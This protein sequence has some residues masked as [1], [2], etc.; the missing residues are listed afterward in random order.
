MANEA[1]PLCAAPAALKDL[2]P[3]ELFVTAIASA[4]RWPMS[5]TTFACRTAED[6]S[7]EAITTGWISYTADAIILGM[8]AALTPPRA[9]NLRQ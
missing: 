9:P 2:G 8:H 1:R 6:L 5:A 4:F 3:V 7:K